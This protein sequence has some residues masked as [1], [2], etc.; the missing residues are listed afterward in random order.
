MT[1]FKA[2]NADMTCTMGEG[3]FQYRLGVAAAADRSKCGRTGLHA[4]EY[5]L[6]CTGY[7]SLGGGNRFFLA[8]ARGDIAEDGQDTRIACT[9]LTL[10][11]ELTNREMAAHA[12]LY[13]VRHPKRAGWEAKGEHLEAAA[14]RA[15][16]MLPDAIAIARGARP[17]ARGAAGAHL[18]LVRETDGEIVDARL[19]T[20]GRDGIR[21]GTWYTVEGGTVKEAV[22]L[23]GP[24]AAS[25]ERLEEVCR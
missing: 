18:G 17:V 19:V 15:E 4:C 23:E 20:V 7:Y 12:M 6:D 13:M 25:I 3:T 2:T 22:I 14:D 24:A 16:A 8:E 11:Q 21:P 9:E 5:I 10:V 1:V